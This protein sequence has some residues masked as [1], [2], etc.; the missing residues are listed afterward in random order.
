MKPAKPSLSRL[1]E[2]K[3]VQLLEERAQDTQVKENAA[4][5]HLRLAKRKMKQA[6]RTFKLAKKLAKRASKEAKAARKAWQTA[7]DEPI[8]PV[9]PVKQAGRAQKPK[10]ATRAQSKKART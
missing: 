2:D 3:G 10:P 8:K 4:V 5:I 9:K 6:K 7:M 1:K